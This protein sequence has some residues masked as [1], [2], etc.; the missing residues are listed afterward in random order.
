MPTAAAS[1]SAR[2]ETSVITADASY[3]SSSSS[4]HA[5]AVHT[6]ILCRLTQY[7]AAS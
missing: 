3:Y 7:A 1:G 5:Y 2:C 6:T 4:V